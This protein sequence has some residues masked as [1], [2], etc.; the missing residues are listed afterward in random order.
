MSLATTGDSI[1]Q[2]PSRAPSMYPAPRDTVAAL[3]YGSSFRSPVSA[4]SGT[5]PVAPSNATRTARWLDPPDS[6]HTVHGGARVFANSME[7]GWHPPDLYSLARKAP[8]CHTAGVRSGARRKEGHASFVV[9]NAAQ[10]GSAFFVG[11]PGTPAHISLA[12]QNRECGYTAE[13]A[14]ET[15]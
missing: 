3:F 2:T 14:R 5:R 15:V 13:R 10:A 4:E 9:L 1:G 7:A 6:T 12:E 8:G 11:V